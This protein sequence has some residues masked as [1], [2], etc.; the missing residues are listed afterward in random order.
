MNK[1]I[2]DGYLL[3]LLIL[4][5]F[6]GLTA[7]YTSVFSFDNA[8]SYLKMQSLAFA[9]G[10]ACF[11]ILGLFKP[12]IFKK[13]APIIFI[14]SVAALV[15]V[16]IFGTGLKETGGQSWIKIGNIS[17]QPSEFVKIAFIITFSAHL[18]KVRDNINSAKVLSLLLLHAAV[19]IVLIALEPDIGTALVF[20]FITVSMLFFAGLS[21]KY[22]TIDGLL[23]I[24]SMPVM[25]AL[26]KNYQKNR[27]LVFLNPE[28]DPTGYGYNVIQS[29]L[30]L[31]SGKIFGQGFLQG[32]ITQ[33]EM[34]PSKHTDFIFSVIGEEF[35]L[36]GCI[37]V[38]VILLLIIMRL[39]SIGIRSKDTFSGLMSCGLSAML[40]FHTF[41]NIGMCIG[42]MPVTGIPLPFI[43]YG[44]SSV[45]AN[46]AA[47]G[48][49]SATY[50]HTNGRA[51][52]RKR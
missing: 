20:V 13:C 29:K 33:G 11:F 42:L 28:L 48:L 14:V 5:S 24:I 9:I 32:K 23:F 39:F 49:A 3:F 50:A 30:A 2:T 34:L 18:T 1:K 47:A 6:C 12:H 16:L 19:F 8:F 7:V 4:I 10:F 25:W 43:S 17:F 21:W 44:G 26:L 40:L 52:G 22:F 36:I 45:I 35:G 41:I 15:A 51:K 46:F 31:G 38:T 37:I 27:I